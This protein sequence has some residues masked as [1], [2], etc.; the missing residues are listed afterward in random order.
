V[1]SADEAQVS[2]AKWWAEHWRPQA[3]GDPLLEVRDGD[4][5]DP[6]LREPAAFGCPAL[7]GNWIVYF[8]VEPI[9]GLGPSTIVVVSKSTGAILFGGSAGDEG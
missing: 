5:W 8:T 7:A 4:D 9:F 6:D 1:I 2:A 3:S